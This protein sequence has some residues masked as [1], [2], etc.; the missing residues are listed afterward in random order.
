MSRVQPG[1]NPRRGASPIPAQAGRAVGSWTRSSALAGLNRATY[2]GLKTFQ[3]VRNLGYVLGSGKP[4]T[5][6]SWSHHLNVFRR[7]S[8]ARR[9]TSVP[10]FHGCACKPKLASRR[11]TD[12]ARPFLA[13]HCPAAP[14]RCEHGQGRPRVRT[15]FCPV[16]SRFADAVVVAPLVSK[17]MF[18][19]S[20]IASAS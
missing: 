5:G 10:F 14:R 17:N 18:A 7:C 19:L 8:S 13:T 15:S 3:R 16:Y 6:Y 9:E 1:S 2:S 4:A 20:L 11:L 12:Q